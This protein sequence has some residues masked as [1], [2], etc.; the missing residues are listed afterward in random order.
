M[1]SAPHKWS[2]VFCN[3]CIWLQGRN[4][5]KS[6]QPHLVWKIGYFVS[7]EAYPIGVAFQPPQIQS[8]RPLAWYHCTG[9]K[10]NTTLKSFQMVSIW[11]WSPFWSRDENC[12]ILQQESRLM[13]RKIHPMDH[14][15][16]RLPLQLSVY[17]IN[18]YTRVFSWIH[19]L[20]IGPKL[21]FKCRL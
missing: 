9:E 18:E 2:N 13:G 1:I 4:F 17:E 7:K 21:F 6:S 12:P 14:L 15:I 16:S 3:I 20:I 19:F 11:S 10:V 5:E 8:M